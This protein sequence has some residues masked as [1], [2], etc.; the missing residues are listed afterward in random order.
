MATI[1]SKT[2]MPDAGAPDNESQAEPISD[3]GLVIEQDVEDAPVE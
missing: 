2:N 1:V 3:R